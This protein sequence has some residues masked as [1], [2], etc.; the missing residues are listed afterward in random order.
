MK[1]RYAALILVSA[2]ALPAMAQTTTST[3]AGQVE[4]AAAAKVKVKVAESLAS[5]AR[6]SAD[7]AYAI[8]RRNASN[9]EVSS[10]ELES[11]GGRLVYNVHVLNKGKRASTVKVDAMTGE[12]LDATEHGGLK[13]TMMHHKENKKLLDAKRDSAAKNP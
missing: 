4:P 7:T 6:V 12:V 2:F 3:S 10:A 13:S 11:S 5:T 9:G 1:T 8:A